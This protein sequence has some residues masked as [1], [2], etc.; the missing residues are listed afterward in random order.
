MVLGSGIW[1][2]GSEIRDPGSGKN[3]FR[4]PD[5]RSRGQKG[6]GSRIRIRNTVCDNLSSH[7]SLEAISLCRENN[8][9]NVCLPPNS[10]DKMQPL[11]EQ[12]GSYFSELK[13]PFFCF[14]WGLK[15]LNSLMRTRDPGSGMETVR[16]RDPGWK[17]VG[18]G[19]NISD[20]PH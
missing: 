5:P 8:I 3:P 19:I 18:S 12:P 10:T 15:Y 14:F 16:I 2:P 9:E 7:V 1:D 6:T 13:K 17:K 4:I 20:P 11:D